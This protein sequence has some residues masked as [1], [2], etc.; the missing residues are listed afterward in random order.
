MTT[1]P[2]SKVTIPPASEGQV[3]KTKD[4]E[5]SDY[6][7]K[8]DSRMMD[9][10][11]L[12]FLGSLSGKLGS[13]AAVKKL[14][15]GSTMVQ[16]DIEQ[17]SFEVFLDHLRGAS[18]FS[19]KDSRTGEVHPVMAAQ[20]SRNSFI[21]YNIPMEKLYEIPGLTSANF[22]ERC[23]LRTDKGK[24]LNMSRVFSRELK[25]IFNIALEE[26]QAKAPSL[27]TIVPSEGSSTADLKLKLKACDYLAT[28]EPN[29]DVAVFAESIRFIAPFSGEGD[30]GHYLVFVGENEDLYNL[31][32]NSRPPPGAAVSPICVLKYGKDECV[33]CRE[34]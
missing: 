31:Y 2:K 1:D 14:L 28:L 12:G 11:E 27:D 34:S 30:S 6:T 10:S 13:P 18:R 33:L 29:F 9:E 17:F 15:T 32:V 25:A 20:T 16:C 21:I 26:K 3:K 8:F 19:I 23:M 22:K 7:V 24:S 5:K 4:L